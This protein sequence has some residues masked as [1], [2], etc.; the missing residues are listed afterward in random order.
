[1]IRFD[2]LK[3]IFDAKYFDHL[4]H[5]IKKTL[6]NRRGQT[7]SHQIYQTQIIMNISYLVNRCNKI[8]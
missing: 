8:F 1:M 3:N 4:S 2:L 6:F 5:Y 7:I